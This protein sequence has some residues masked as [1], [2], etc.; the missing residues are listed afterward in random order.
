MKFMPA[1][2]V[3]WILSISFDEE[4]I[5]RSYNT[6]YY[7]HQSITR[8][9]QVVWSAISCMWFT[10]TVQNVHV[11]TKLVFAGPLSKHIHSIIYWR[12]CKICQDAWKIKKGEHRTN[13]LYMNSLFYTC[14]M[15]QASDQALLLHLIC[16][17]LNERN[18]TA[19]YKLTAWSEYKSRLWFPDLWFQNME[20]TISGRRISNKTNLLTYL[21][22]EAQSFFRS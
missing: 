8:N 21:L 18:G 20:Y 17:A 13:V 15:G 1:Y 9:I 19:E 22:H 2:S 16:M 11:C 12:P 6:L 5:M 3:S 4:H 7:Q 14:M 10:G